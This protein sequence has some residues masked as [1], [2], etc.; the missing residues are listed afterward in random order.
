[1]KTLSPKKSMTDDA[2]SIF[3]VLFS[4]LYKKMTWYKKPSI[5]MILP[6]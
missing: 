1:M 5:L 3:M 2:S 4:K 6:G